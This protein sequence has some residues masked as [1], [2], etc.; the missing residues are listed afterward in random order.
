MEVPR[1]R[2]NIRMRIRARS[3]LGVEADGRIGQYFVDKAAKTRMSLNLVPDGSP[4]L[5][6]QHKD[7]HSRVVIGADMDGKVFQSFFEWKNR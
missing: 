3:F 6:V 4:S 7:E 2:P 5:I 1:S